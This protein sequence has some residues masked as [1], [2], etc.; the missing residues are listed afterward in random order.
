MQPK[1]KKMEAKEKKNKSSKYKYVCFNKRIDR[2]EVQIKRGGRVVWKM[3]K[4]EREA[5]IVADK[6]LL[7]N[8]EEAV[9]ILVKK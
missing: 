9:N 4:T 2:W 8:G 7:N 6:W 3:C 5:A 1:E